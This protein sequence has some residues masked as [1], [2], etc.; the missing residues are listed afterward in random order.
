MFVAPLLR[1]SGQRSTLPT[2]GLS[3][4]GHVV[5]GLSGQPHP[6][7]EEDDE[8]FRGRWGFEGIVYFILSD[9]GSE[10]GKGLPAF[11]IAWCCGR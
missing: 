1:M 3:S 4:L 6:K 10:F 2:A 5:R 7:F 11:L 8:Q 9:A